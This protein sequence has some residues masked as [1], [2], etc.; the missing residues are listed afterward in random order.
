MEKMISMFILN[1]FILEYK[2]EVKPD[3]KKNMLDFFY[4]LEKWLKIQN[5]R[6]IWA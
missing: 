2:K 1:Y 6:H 4:M 3:L 5:G